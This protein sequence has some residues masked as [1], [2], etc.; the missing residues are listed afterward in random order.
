MNR[1]V[2]NQ[3]DVIP[4][5]IYAAKST[6]DK[7]GSIP[8]QL[9]DCRKEIA[10]HPDGTTREIVGEHQDEARSAYK[11]NRGPGL[12]AAKR[13][14]IE[15]AK[16]RGSA[17]L[18]VQHSD[19]LA[20]GDGLSADHL[21]EVFFAMRRAR[22]RLR[23]VQDDSNLQNAIHAVLIGERNHEDSHRK[24]EAVKAGL[25]RV[26]EKGKRAGSPVPDGYLSRP[27][28]DEVT[29]ERTGTSYVADPEREAT[30][31]RMWALAESGM[32]PLVIAR[33]LNSEGY[34]KASGRPWD[35]RGVESKLHNA[36]YAGAVVWHGEINWD[37]KT[38]QPTYLSRETW[39]KIEGQRKLR[40]RA[41]GSDRKPGQ[42]RR[43]HLLSGLARCSRCGEPMY[44]RTS[45]YRRKSDGGRKR[46]YLCSTVHA[47]TGT[48]D[49]PLV[50]AELIDG[51]LV[52][53]LAGLVADFPAWSKSIASARV[54]EQ[55]AIE[56][57]LK[58]ARSELAKTEGKVRKVEDRYAN[59][60][61]EDAEA[62]LD[63]L[64]RL[65][66]ERQTLND[67]TASLEVE[68][69]RAA[70]AGRG[71]ADNL[72]DFYNDL[73][74]AIKGAISDGSLMDANAAL[75]DRFSTFWIDSKPE[76]VSVVPELRPELLE[77]LVW[78]SGDFTE[79]EARAR[80]VSYTEHDDRDHTAHTER[81][82]S[83]PG[84]PTRLIPEVDSQNTQLYLCTNPNRVAFAAN[85]PYDAGGPMSSSVP[86]RCSERPGGATILGSGFAANS[87][88]CSASERN[89][90]LITRVTPAPLAAAAIRS[91]ASATSG[92]MPCPCRF[93]SGP[94]YPPPDATG[95]TAPIDTGAPTLASAQSVVLLPGRPPSTFERTETLVRTGANEAASGNL[96]T[97]V[98]GEAPLRTAILTAVSLARARYWNLLMWAGFGAPFGKVGGASNRGRSFFI[99][100]AADSAER[101]AVVCALA[102]PV[103]APAIATRATVP[104]TSTKIDPRINGVD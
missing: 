24:S 44:G 55:D 98:S 54:A 87:A 12:E 69:N 13:A 93:A 99:E 39:E 52:E 25:R 76:G 67:R 29:G 46:K 104:R 83:D 71:D 43:N 41:G 14:A 101:S 37:S 9:E 94:L 57:E 56:A 89:P 8:T 75:L 95:G 70:K 33:K 81:L 78:D 26:K 65:R 72:L 22:V 86:Q 47:G 103:I 58:S 62:L 90:E 96:T 53:N 19:R 32:P 88:A 100:R 38:E 6:E 61:G 18:W 35:R 28:I 84:F 5:V 73:Q 45:T 60:E 1:N 11:G 3:Q 97:T 2:A 21:A 16:E 102:L 10:A 30:I 31:A 20:R 27:V 4:V 74:E 64:K 49:A 48:C 92:L 40:D 79:G 7:R 17:E 66:S 59:A 23:S 91:K 82:D 85:Q 50:D 80:V 68:A 77:V 15:A 51:A 63:L 34:R 42:P 36:F